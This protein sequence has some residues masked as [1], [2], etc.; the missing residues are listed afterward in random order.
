MYSFKA[1]ITK[2]TEKWLF[3][4]S[5]SCE[6]MNNENDNKKKDWW[7]IICFSKFTV[8]YHLPSSHPKFFFPLHLF[9]TPP[10]LLPIFCS[11]SSLLPPIRFFFFKESQNSLLFLLHN[12]T[13]FNSSSCSAPHLVSLLFHNTNAFRFPNFSRWSQVCNL[14]LS[15]PSQSQQKNFLVWSKRLRLFQFSLVSF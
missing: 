15:S 14:T 9:F 3:S 4:E 2:K 12:P 8:A 6:L 13:F 1:E 10:S 11:S 5:A 7:K